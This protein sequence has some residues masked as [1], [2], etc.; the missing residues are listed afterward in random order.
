MCFKKCALAVFLLMLSAVPGWG[1][2]SSLNA[3]ETALKSGTGVIEV[4]A[5]ITINSDTTLDGGTSGRTLKFTG[6]K[7]SVFEITGG[8][9][10]L[11]NL[12]IT[13]GKGYGGRMT[14]G[15]GMLIYGTPK[16]TAENCVFTENTV[17]NCGGGIFAGGGTL[18][19]RNCTFNENTAR[20][21]G[22]INAGGSAAITLEN[23]AFNGNTARGASGGGI[24]LMGDEATL[25]MYSCTFKENLVSGDAWCSGGGVVVDSCATANLV[26]CTFEGNTVNSENA[27]GGGI[28][29]QSSTAN[30]VNCTFVGN[31]ASGSGASG[32]EIHVSTESTLNAANTIFWN[33]E[34]AIVTA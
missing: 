15:G 34:G 17:S 13:G 23:C 25:Y 9:V 18:T 27:R 19:M 10:T 31:T 28:N 7:G 26:N 24:R 29:I 11:R 6:T 21:G 3:L 1:A 4:S 20:F 22:G 12:T 32:H 8:K 2:V 5:T 16:V 14:D 30:L 33:P